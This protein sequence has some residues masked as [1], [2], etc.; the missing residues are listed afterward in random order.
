MSGLTF[1]SLQRDW[2]E[3]SVFVRGGEVT[4]L[5]EKTR[6][7]WISE[8]FARISFSWAQS[9]ILYLQHE[10]RHGLL[11]VLPGSWLVAHSCFIG[12]DCIGC[13]RLRGISEKEPDVL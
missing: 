6:S 3:S 4:M 10:I 5:T 12:H 11:K 13:A 8:L 1:Y 9:Y 2:R 7:I